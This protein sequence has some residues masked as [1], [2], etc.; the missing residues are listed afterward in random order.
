MA[1]LRCLVSRGGLADF[2]ARSS[3]VTSAGRWHDSYQLL[4][5][6]LIWAELFDVRGLRAC[7]AAE[8]GAQSRT[9]QSFAGDPLPPGSRAPDLAM[10]A[11]EPHQRYLR[12]RFGPVA[13]AWAREPLRRIA[14]WRAFPGRA[15]PQEV[16][17]YIAAGTGTAPGL[18]QQLPTLLESLTGPSPHSLNTPDIC[19]STW[20]SSG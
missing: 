13:E 16:E 3:F 6:A 5:A 11:P 9:T 2:Q 10:T 18:L 12:A 4:T 17:Q 20:W 7:R 1:I 19:A 15:T 8:Q 14:A